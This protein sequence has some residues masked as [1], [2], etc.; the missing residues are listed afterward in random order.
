LIIPVLGLFAD[1][2][3]ISSPLPNYEWQVV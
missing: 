3:A 1:I 2:W